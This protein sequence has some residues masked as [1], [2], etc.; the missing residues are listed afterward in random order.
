MRS[1]GLE[2]RTEPPVARPDGYSPWFSLIEGRAQRVL[3]DR[4]VIAGRSSQ[5]DALW[6]R[7]DTRQPL[8][9]AFAQGARVGAR[10]FSSAAAGRRASGVAGGGVASPGAWRNH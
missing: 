8:W 2:V 7:L 4:E 5:G 9:V 6:L 1:N 10:Q 3:D